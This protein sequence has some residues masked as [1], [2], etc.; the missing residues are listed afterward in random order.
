MCAG[1]SVQR[2]G[3]CRRSN[4]MARNSQGDWIGDIFDGRGCGE[5]FRQREL[6]L[7]GRRIMLVGARG[8]RLGNRHC[9]S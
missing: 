4:A 5:A 1:T 9:Y 6:S 3:P 8:R 2:S 7:K